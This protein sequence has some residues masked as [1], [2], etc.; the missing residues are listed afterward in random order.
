[1]KEFIKNQTKIVLDEGIEQTPEVDQ[2]IDEML[3]YQIEHP[4]RISKTKNGNRLSKVPV[5]ELKSYKKNFT[6]ITVPI[7]DKTITIYPVFGC[8]ASDITED[9]IKEC[10][11]FSTDPIFISRDE[12]GEL[13]V[14]A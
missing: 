2:I 8:K 7:D 14:G 3:T 9:D 12:D 1:M 13:Y 5:D 11:E 10:I 6:P 4:M